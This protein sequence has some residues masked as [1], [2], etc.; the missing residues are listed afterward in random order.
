[1]QVKIK[2]IAITKEDFNKLKLASET[3]MTGKYYA[4]L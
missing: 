1:M 3:K 4:L 2:P